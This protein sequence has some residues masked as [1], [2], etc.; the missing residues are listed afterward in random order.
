MCKKEYAVVAYRVQY[1]VST[2]PWPVSAWSRVH[3]LTK[4]H[5]P[6]WVLT[7]FIVDICTLEKLWRHLAAQHE[8]TD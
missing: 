5:Y 8:A 1:V 7:N 2:I 3:S 4:C 6:K